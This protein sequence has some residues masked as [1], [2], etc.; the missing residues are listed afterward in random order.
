MRTMIIGSSSEEGRGG[1]GFDLF[2]DTGTVSTFCST[3]VFFTG[4]GVGTVTRLPM[5]AASSLEMPPIVETLG[6][7]FAI[8]IGVVALWCYGVVATN[9]KV[10]VPECV[11]SYSNRF[12]NSL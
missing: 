5:A 7:F 1:A 6:L 8:F 4:V 10:I 9:H 12:K 11:S 2:G 3:T